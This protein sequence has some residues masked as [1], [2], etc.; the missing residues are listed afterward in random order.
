[1]DYVRRLLDR[2]ESVGRAGEDRRQEEAEEILVG[3]QRVWAEF[4]E[5]A[6]LAGVQRIILLEHAGVLNILRRS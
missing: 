5:A 2:S 1:M 4:L 3:G 6:G